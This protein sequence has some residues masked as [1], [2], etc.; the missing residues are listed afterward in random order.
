MAAG[1]L[2][3][4]P[5]PIGDPADLGARAARL[6]REV[7]LLYAE[8]TRSARRL[9]DTLGIARAARSCHDANETARAVE[10][11]EHLRQGR[12]VGL[13]SEAG[14]PG[15]SD[16]GHRV[17]REALAAGARV[18][19]VPGP[20]A[21]LAALVASGLPT[22]RFFY[23]GFGP[24]KGKPRADWLAMLAGIPATLVLFESPLRAADTLAELAE[25]LGDRPACLCRELS[26]V[27]EELVRGGLRE[28]AARYRDA[29]PLGEITLV[30][31]GP[32]TLAKPGAHRPRLGAAPAAEPFDDDHLTTRARALL[33]AG[34]TVRDTTRR[35]VAETR[36]SRGR[37]YPIVLAVRDAGGPRGQNSSAPSTK[38]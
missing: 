33:D 13:M 8:D 16:P 30:V 15:I 28:L 38:N 17:V 29:R 11:A 24:R 5:T 34:L 36:L 12:M 9:L 4:I 6:L 23:A 26:K 2:Y 27:H 22:D 21:V 35:L 10:I 32:A 3:L 25:A 7:E 31:G 20:S 18:V 1:T 37:V 14:M 19:P